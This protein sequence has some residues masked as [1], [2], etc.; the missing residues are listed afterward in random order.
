MPPMIVDEDDVAGEDVHMKDVD[1]KSLA[2]APTATESD[3]DEN[4]AITKQL[5]GEKATTNVVQ[6]KSAMLANTKETAKASPLPKS[7]TIHSNTDSATINEGNGI[8]TTNKVESRSVVKSLDR[9]AKPSVN[10]TKTPASHTNK[11]LQSVEGGDRPPNM[12]SNRLAKDMLRLKDTLDEVSHKAAQNV[13]R[14]KWRTFLFDPPDESHVAFVLRAG[15]KNSTTGILHRVIKDDNVFKQPFVDLAAQKPALRKRVLETATPEEILRHMD[16]AAL[17]AIVASTIATV[18]VQQL[19]SWL[20]HANRLGF[21]E[22][23]IQ[24]GS[25]EI[26]TPNVTTNLSQPPAFQSPY[27]N[28][29]PPPQ[30]YAHQSPQQTHIAVPVR[31]PQAVHVS[32][33]P[34]QSTGSNH[35]SDALLEQQNRLRAAAAAHTGPMICPD[36]KHQFTTMPGFQHHITKKPC[37]RPI[38]PEGYRIMCGNCLQ[39]FT[40]KQGHDYH[41]LKRVCLGDDDSIH[42]NAP[43]PPPGFMAAA[44]TIPSNDGLPSIIGSANPYGIQGHS[45]WP[46]DSRPSTSRTPSFAN[47]NARQ[48]SVEIVDGSSSSVSKPKKEK[49]NAHHT[50]SATTTPTTRKQQ[51]RA[52][53]DVRIDPSQ[54]PP[55]RLAQ[56]NRDLQ[57]VDDR[58]EEG[59]AN[60]PDDLAEPEKEAKR[61]GLKN[62]NSS[63][64]SQIRKAYGVTLRMREKDKQY[65]AAL[66][67]AGNDSSPGGS[68][69]ASPAPAGAHSSRPAFDAVRNS[70]ETRVAAT[71]P[72][73]GFSPVNAPVTRTLPPTNMI[74]GYGPYNSVQAPTPTIPA[75]N[76]NGYTRLDMNI[77]QYHPSDVVKKPSSEQKPTSAVTSGAST[78]S[79]SNP[80]LKRRHEDFEHE[81]RPG[82]G[83]GGYTGSIPTALKS[84]T[85]EGEGD[86]VRVAGAAVN[87]GATETN[88]LHNAGTSTPTNG[89]RLTAESSGQREAKVGSGGDDRTSVASILNMVNSA[90]KKTFKPIVAVNAEDS[91]DDDSVRSIDA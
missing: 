4:D 89:H 17:S 45:A 39:G 56:L 43:P 7:A 74:N 26:F 55:E 2:A 31:Q 80:M 83:Q 30:G 62:A 64:K 78:P 29:P 33:D 6:K 18:P 72:T 27:S 35:G 16:S 65:K 52:P 42:T 44:N 15:L 87:K 32:S 57:D 61:I 90:S 51:S 10:G 60:I 1:T 81:K 5:L 84:R 91:S 12:D 67:R 47:M 40:T 69:N 68:A 70:T 19:V 63:R 85:P 11:V 41:F 21:D 9:P 34:L 28:P 46:Q 20:G 54:L 76:P 75:R 49:R 48:H 37:T 86:K 8:D 66:M 14:E 71:A 79:T 22:S 50:P 13:L 3:H 23:D 36:C 59:L 82:S 73:S 88:S 58:Y 38:P 77:K 25:T 53:N 24:K